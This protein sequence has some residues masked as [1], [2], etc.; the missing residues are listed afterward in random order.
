[1]RAAAHQADDVERMQAW[2]ER[3]AA[4]PSAIPASEMVRSL[5]DEARRILGR[6]NDREMSSSHRVLAVA[7]IEC[8]TV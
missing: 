6:T 4:L 3:S 7:L 1:M 2:A 5:W 8:A